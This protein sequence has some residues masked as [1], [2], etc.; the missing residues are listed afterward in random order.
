MESFR[1]AH[2]EYFYF[3]LVIPVFTV[4]F[5]LSRI[6]RR[7]SLRMFGDNALIEQ[8]MPSVSTSRPINKFI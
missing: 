7:R 4:F 5:I 1:F 8:L 6:N 3:L 2:P